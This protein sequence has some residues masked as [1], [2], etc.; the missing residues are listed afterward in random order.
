MKK[1]VFCLMSLLSCFGPLPAQDKRMEIHVDFRVGSS[2]LDTAYSD[3]ATRL[4]EITSYL[5]E[6]ENDSLLELVEVSFCGSASPEGSFAI[7][8]KLA[9][10]RRISLERYVR[11][12]IRLPNNVIARRDNVIAWERLSLLVEQSDM[13]HKKEVLDILRDVPEFTYTPKGAVVDSRKKRLMDLQYG[14]AWKYMHTRFFGRMRN[15]AA[16]VVTVRR[17]VV[18]IKKEI[19]EQTELAIAP[20]DTP[21]AA[22]K[23]T[24]TVFQP[25]EPKP[26]YMNVKTNM[27]YDALLVPNIGV[28]FHLGR[29]WSLAA[30]WMYAWWKSD[31]KHNYWRAYGGDMAIRKWFGKK[32]D[33]KPLTG[34]HAGLYG[35]LF[36][37]D[38]ERGGKGYMGGK[39]GGTLWD[40]LNYA[41]GVEYGYSLPVTG[42][43]NIDFTLGLGYW[44]GK[45]YEYTP[46]DGHYVWQVTRNRHWF[47]P[48]KAEISLVWLLGRGNSNRGKEGGAR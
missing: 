17:N 35:Q 25:E 11:G 5:K 9:T 29:N 1:Y 44:G 22:V 18:E 41:A 33:E 6:V 40:E 45:Y 8:R 31:R 34:H 12:S 13:P 42:R 30:N 43:L 20:A 46:I 26:F 19:P 47:G 21:V 23:E 48:T 14:R 32:A 39:P 38:F 27:L 37:Y 24:E 10:E 7:N 16:V 36:T 28:E 2:E 4:S 15:A 3:N